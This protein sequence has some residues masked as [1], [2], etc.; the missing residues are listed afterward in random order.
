MSKA[1][2][3]LPVQGQNVTATLLT[4]DLA[5]EQGKW[6]VINHDTGLIDVWTDG[7]VAMLDRMVVAPTRPAPVHVNGR[8]A[9]PLSKHSVTWN[10]EKVSA[11]IVRVLEAY[12]KAGSA[13]IVG[14]TPLQPYLSPRDYQQASA[15]AVDAVTRGF[16]EKN[17]Q[18]R[19][20]TISG[21]DIVEH[22]AE[23]AQPQ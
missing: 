15:R 7:Q 22:C 18:Y 12:Q 2:K 23:A 9:A 4:A 1:S 20:L 11:Q 16:L 3:R 8:R 5:I 17:G 10:G 6:V 13:N 14:I 21:V 19:S